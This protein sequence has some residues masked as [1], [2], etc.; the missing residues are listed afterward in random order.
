MHHPNS[1]RAVHRSFRLFFTLFIA[2]VLFLPLVTGPALADEKAL[3]KKA[4]EAFE[5]KRW[6]EAQRLFERIRQKHPKNPQPYYFLGEIH[7]FHD[8]PARAARFWRLYTKLDAAGAAS[9]DVPRRL[10]L[11]EDKLRKRS[12]ERMLDNEASL[13]KEP[14]DPNTVAV[15][16]FDHN[17]Q[18]AY[19]VL[20]KGITA[21]VIADLAKVPGI[22]VLERV[23]VQKLV[24]EI[25]L[26]KS[27]LV[28]DHKVRAGRLLK[29]QKLV[30]GDYRVR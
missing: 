15:F 11:L 14:P 23:K 26:H 12:F 18:E 3:V 22:K 2:W 19:R 6:G 24:Q 30:T 25:A 10:T 1:N 21:L 7:L 16:P 17:G 29:A 27:G 4:V 13:S 28:G 8:R 9:H 5:K 20:S